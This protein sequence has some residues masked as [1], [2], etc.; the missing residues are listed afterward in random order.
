M[1]K[2]YKPLAPDI[3]E[4]RD[5][6]LADALAY[7]KGLSVVEAWRAR[8]RVLERVRD[9]TGTLYTARSHSMPYDPWMA[10]A[11]Y[12]EHLST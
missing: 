9:E 11:I 10:Q 2:T 7:V 12:A 6:R 5:T 1:T 8:E 4:A 3:T